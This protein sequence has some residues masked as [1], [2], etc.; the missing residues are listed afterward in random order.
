MRNIIIFS[1]WECRLC[2]LWIPSV[3]ILEPYISER[4]EIVLPMISP[5]LL[6]NFLLVKGSKYFIFTWLWKN[7]WSIIN[8]N[9]KKIKLSIYFITCQDLILKTVSNM[10]FRPALPSNLLAPWW[11]Y[12]IL[13]LFLYS[14]YDIF[15]LFR[16]SLHLD[17]KQLRHKGCELFIFVSSLAT[18]GPSICWRNSKWRKKLG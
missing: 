1:L 5:H 2:V 15:Q 16:F 6:L 11:H 14:L 8:G 13:Q 17:Y 10:M 18:I 3:S 12:S 7:C 4:T 9:L